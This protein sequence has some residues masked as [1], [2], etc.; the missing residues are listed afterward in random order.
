[1]I[2]HIYSSRHTFFLSIHLSQNKVI[3]YQ[4]RE[5]LVRNHKDTWVAIPPDG[6]IKTLLLRSCWLFEGLLIH[7][8]KHKLKIFLSQLIDFLFV[9][10]K[11]FALKASFLMELQGIQFQIFSLVFLVRY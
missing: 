4:V 3:R 7:M 8:V 2:L 10:L 5:F 6:I 1:M 9:Q 11:A